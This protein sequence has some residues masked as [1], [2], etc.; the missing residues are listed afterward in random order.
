ML[1]MLAN[2]GHLWAF[3]C[4]LLAM[5]IQHAGIAAWQSCQQVQIVRLPPSVTSLAE[6]T[7]QR[8]YVLRQ[9]AAPG[10][11]RHCRRVFAECCSP[12]RVGDSHETED[13]NVLARA[14]LDKYAF[15]S[16]LTLTTITLHG[17][18]QQTS[19]AA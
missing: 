1:Q 4:P 13:S 9:V 6:G 18:H 16:C 11:V 19:S 15:E 17:L 3:D 5:G 10:C 12:G 8:C 2:A 7:F 14:Q